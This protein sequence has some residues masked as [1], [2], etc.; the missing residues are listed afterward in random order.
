MTDD[1]H[2]MNKFFAKAFLEIFFFAI[3]ETLQSRDGWWID[4][5]L[6]KREW[7]DKK[8]DFKF[9][10]SI[11]N[12]YFKLNIV[13]NIWYELWIMNIADVR[14]EERISKVKKFPLAFK[15]KFNGKL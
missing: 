6:K 10:W 9:I 4:R 7:R 8:D 2:A 15:F 14:K 5:I 1:V 11:L 13:I 12:F 3:Q